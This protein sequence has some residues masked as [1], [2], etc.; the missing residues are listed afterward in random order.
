MG[1]LKPEVTIAQAQ[2]EME[3]IAG[4]LAE[5]HPKSNTNWGIS[6]EPLHNNFLPETTIK[7]LW[8]LL[9]TVL[10]CC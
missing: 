10:S 1:R 7:N 2:S 8:M 3:M 4:Q 5:E 6:V 9:G